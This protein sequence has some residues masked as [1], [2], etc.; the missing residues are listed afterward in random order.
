MIT[1]VLLSWLSEAY[2]LFCCLSVI[3][4]ESHMQ[5]M[6]SKHQ[7]DKFPNQLQSKPLVV[8]HPCPS[9]YIVRVHEG[10]VRKENLYK[11]Q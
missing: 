4:E 8:L 5:G 3:R 7:I 2:G 6:N 9:K 10:I 11:M 1:K